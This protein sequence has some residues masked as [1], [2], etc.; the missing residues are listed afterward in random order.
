[1]NQPNWD[2]RNSRGGRRYNRGRGKEEEDSHVLTLDEWER[3][4]AG[5]NPSMRN[6]FPDVRQDEDLAWQLQ[7]QFDLEDHSVSVFA[8]TVYKHQGSFIMRFC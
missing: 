1:M 2:N 6:E 4:K 3:R 8:V 5:A 7:N